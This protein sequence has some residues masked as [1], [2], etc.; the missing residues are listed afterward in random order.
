MRRTSAA[1]RFHGTDGG[2]EV[3]G[4]PPKA[5]L[6]HRRADSDPQD[7]QADIG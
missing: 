3:E 4:L 7:Q 6:N 2:I 5:G 1:A